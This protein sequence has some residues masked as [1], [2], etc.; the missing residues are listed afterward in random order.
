MRKQL[1]SWRVVGSAAQIIQTI[2]GWVGLSY[3]LRTS[4]SNCA[5]TY[6]PVDKPAI[7]AVREIAS[8]SGASVMLDRNG[9][10]QIFDW[11]EAFARG[12][13]HA[14]PA[15]HHRV[16]GALRPLLHQPRERG[17][18]QLRRG[19]QSPGTIPVE[20]TESLARAPGEKI[21]SERIEIRDYVITPNL[22]RGMARERLA[23]AWV[24]ANSTRFVGPAEGAQSIRPLSGPVLS[25]NRTLNWNGRAY[26]YEI[27]VVFARAAV[28]FAGS[29]SSTG[30]VINK[31]GQPPQVH[32]GW[33]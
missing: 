12:G 27:A 3:Q 18:H 6:I 24:E 10:L 14:Q 23:R 30:Y 21:V 22:A 1:D 33:W 32:E 28:P 25:V 17:G 29:W 5:Q 20:V 15:R 2:C 7:A 16:R 13:E 26:R 11:E 9:T 4:L 19:R 31:P 8:W